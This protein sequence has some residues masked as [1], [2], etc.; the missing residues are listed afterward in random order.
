MWSLISKEFKDIDLKGNII[1]DPLL[2]LLV[3]IEII[4]ENSLININKFLLTFNNILF[5]THLK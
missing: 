5:N 1:N 2:L 3:E 4:M